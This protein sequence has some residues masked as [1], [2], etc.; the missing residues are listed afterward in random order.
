MD[1]TSLRNP[2][3]RMLRFFV[4]VSFRFLHFH[5][6]L[7]YF[8]FIGGE[9]T[10]GLKNCKQNFEKFLQRLALIQ[11]S[12]LH[13]VSRDG[14]HRVVVVLGRGQLEWYQTKLWP[15]LILEAVTQSHQLLGAQIIS[16]DK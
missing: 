2:F 11:R 15:D 3:H 5:R 7:E 1:T 16:V 14:A 12:H 6:L 9:Y 13:D 10:S 8:F 4:L